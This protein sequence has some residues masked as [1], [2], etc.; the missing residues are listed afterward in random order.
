M[1][2]ATAACAAWRSAPGFSPRMPTLTWEAVRWAFVDLRNTVDY[3]HPVSWLSLML[4]ANLY[5]LWAGGYHATSVIL[6]ALNVALVFRLM[7]RIT[8]DKWSAFA[9]AVFFAVHPLHL[10]SVVWITE[11]KD[12]LFMF[13]GLLALNSYLTWARDRSRTALAAFSCC[14]ALSLMSKPVL[15]VLPG[16]LLLLDYWPLNRWSPFELFRPAGPGPAFRDRLRALWPLLREKLPVLGLAMLST[17]ATVNSH[18]NAHDMLTLD[19]ATRYG[20]AFIS[21]AKYAWKFFVPTNLAIIYTFQTP[22]PLWPLVVSVAGLVAALLFCAWKGQRFP[23]LILGLG[24]FLLGLLTTIVTPKI[25]MHVPMADRFTYFPY[26]GAYL[27]LVLGAREIAARL[28]AD[29]QKRAVAL[30][31]CLLALFGWYWS[32]ASY[33]IEFWRNEYTIYERAIDVSPGQYILYNNY[34]KILVDRLDLARAETYALKSL[35]L[36]PGF[37]LALGN[38][39][40]IY[41]GTGRFEQ[42]IT[43]FRQALAIDPAYAFRASDLYG[44]AYCLAQL[45]RYDEAEQSYLQALET[46]PKYPQAHNDLGNIALLRGNLRRAEEQYAQAVD[47]APDYQVA[48]ENLERVRR[49][50]AGGR[51]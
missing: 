11:R 24:W 43:M 16:L 10:E 21:L 23:W 40:N 6:H 35:A 9:V 3:W 19:S 30:A 31:A 4:D 39:G 12:V 36:Q 34:A 22:V 14:Y 13:W 33:A 27:V 48:R 41:M 5:G 18:V 7:R 38:L 42:A 15:V 1:R 25:G 49:M 26:V 45:G 28:I 37:N 51:Q 44:I 2:R 8:A 17:L 29:R 32:Q 50:L 20:T 46:Q 47:Q